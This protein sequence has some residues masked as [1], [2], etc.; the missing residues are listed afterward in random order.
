MWPETDM[1]DKLTRTSEQAAHDAA[2]LLDRPGI[3]N[4]ITLAGQH[5]EASG[6][7]S[8]SGSAMDSG[9]TEEAC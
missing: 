8:E 4:L 2:A 3:R 1:G 5:G 7:D 9:A 6:G